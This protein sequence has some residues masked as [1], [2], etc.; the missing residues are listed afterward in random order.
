MTKRQQAHRIC[1][2][3][4]AMCAG[5]AT[6]QTTVYRCGPDGRT[7]SERPCADGGTRTMNVDDTRTAEER[8]AAHAV[9]HREAQ[10]ATKLAR[11]NRQYE[12][13]LRPAGATSLSG[14]GKTDKG[15]RAAKAP[16]KSDNKAHKPKTSKPSAPEGFTAVVPGSE[17]KQR[18]RS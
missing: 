1:G 4:L 3:L 16:A 6:A 15:E 7:F 2:A 8:Q 18:R 17:P 5:L 11:D 9:A 14:P 12:R 13:S 10:T